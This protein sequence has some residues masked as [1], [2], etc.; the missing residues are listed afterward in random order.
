GG[1]NMA[2]R[3]MDCGE[4]G[5]ILLSKTVADVLSQLSEWAGHLQDWGEQTVKHGVKLHIFNLY[6]G[7]VGNPEAPEKLRLQRA[8]TIQPPTPNPLWLILSALF[9][10]LTVGLSAVILRRFLGD[11]PDVA[12]VL[13]TLSLGL[14]CLSVGSAFTR[15]VRQW[16][17]SGFFR[18]GVKLKFQGKWQMALALV[19]LLMVGAFYFSLPAVAH[20]YNERAIKFQQ[21]G[22][23]SAALK[24][25]ERAVSLNPGYAVAHYNLAS[26]YEDVQAF[27]EALTEYQTALRADPRFYF[28]YNNLA[29]LYLLR[30][31]DYASALKVLNAALDLKPQ[32][33]QVKYSLYKNRGWAH[34]GLEFYDLAV[35]DLRESL[36]WRPDGAAAHCL[37]AQALE[38]QKKEAASKPEWQD[39][40]GY[41]AGE[42]DVEASWLSLAQERLK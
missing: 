4:A 19:A 39:C 35:A 13:I 16:V 31:K 17:E 8:E 6:T 42:P 40:L 25:F 28:A 12:S 29:R 38:A 27:D 32:E 22:N 33:T 21:A 9:L 10:A 36:D 30:R 15:S 41:A 3:V 23:L 34:F 2:Q 7:E 37:L 1:I 5:H 20:I 26:A 24:S 14:L 18:L 11:A